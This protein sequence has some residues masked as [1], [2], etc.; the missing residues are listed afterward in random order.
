MLPRARTIALLLTLP[1]LASAGCSGGVS[2]AAPAPFENDASPTA[3]RVATLERLTASAPF[4]DETREQVKGVAWQRSEDVAVRLAAIDALLADDEADTRR[5]LALLL[6]TE[7]AWPVIERV[8]ELA[9]ERGWTDLTPALVRSWSRPV[10][11]PVDA[12]RPERA[13][14]LALHPDATM[15]EVVFGVFIDRSLT[16]AFADRTRQDAWALLRR[17]DGTGEASVSLLRDLP[18]EDVDPIVADIRAAAVDLGAIPE[19]ARQLEWLRDMRQP[20]HEAFW[21]E[22]AAAVA[23]LPENR[24]EGLQ[25]RHAAALRWAAANRSDWFDLDRDAL[26]Q[27]LAGR[28]RGRVRHERTGGS[29]F[30]GSRMERLATWRDDLVWA[31]TVSLLIADAAARDPEIAADLFYQADADRLDR[32]CEHGGVLDATPDGFVA[33]GFT[34]RPAQRLGDRRF[35]ASPEMLERGATALF[36]YHFHANRLRNAD[37]AGPSEGDLVYANDFGRACLVFTFVD[38]D[39]LAV[40]YYQPGGARIDLGEIARP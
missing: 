24:R 32:S 11:T 2:T 20:E 37:Y 18:A 12:D 30:T 17:I 38:A 39:T 28:L 27:R 3:G 13:A 6:P 36:H 7:T 1:T 4:D 26:L 40:D 29:G 19:T 22:A 9:V 35:I 33:L 31:D 15:T 14:L 25:L 8:G 23:S 10:P 21:A 34:P 5:M 16:G